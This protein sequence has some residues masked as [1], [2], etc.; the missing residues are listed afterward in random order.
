MNK[1]LALLDKPVLQRFVISSVLYSFFCAS[2]AGTAKS[3]SW[4][5]TA[6]QFHGVTLAR[7]HGQGEAISETN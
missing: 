7:V 1:R 3:S 2:V 5:T 6:F 4:T